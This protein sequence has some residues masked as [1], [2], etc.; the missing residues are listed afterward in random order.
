LTKKIV[1]SRDVIF[2]DLGSWY[3]PKQST[4]ADEDNEIEDR[5]KF[6]NVRDFHRD[7]NNAGQQSPTSTECSGPSK[8]SGGKSDSNSWSGKSV[9]QKKHDDKKGK[10]KMLEYEM[11]DDGSKNMEDAGSDMSLD[12][13]LGIRGLKIPGMEKAC[14]IQCAETTLGHNRA[15]GQITQETGN[16]QHGESA[17]DVNVENPIWEKPRES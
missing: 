8:N 5:D 13:F 12:D 16:T 2:D 9:G 14:Y 4:E 10:Q 11:L 3:N 1:T 6:E 17:Q 15:L 7:G